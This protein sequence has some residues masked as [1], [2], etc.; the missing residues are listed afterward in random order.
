MATTR[1][2]GGT[3]RNNQERHGATGRS[4]PRNE[5]HAPVQPPAPSDGETGQETVHTG[6][7][8]GHQSG[9]CTSATNLFAHNRIAGRTF[10][11]TV[12]TLATKIPAFAV[13]PGC[14]WPF[15]RT[16]TTGSG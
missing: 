13:A 6:H 12:V 14:R 10:Q 15:L 7:R 2:L 9:R 16:R 5:A 1:G 8:V 3:I 4:R 11:L